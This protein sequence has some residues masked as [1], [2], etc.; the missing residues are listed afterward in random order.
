MV[1][2]ID[3]VDY[4][5]KLKENWSYPIATSPVIYQGYQANEAYRGDKWLLTCLRVISAMIA[6]R[7]TSPAHQCY[8]TRD[9]KGKLYLD[10]ILHWTNLAFKEVEGVHKKAHLDVLNC[11]ITDIMIVKTSSV[12]H[13]TIGTAMEEWHS[14]N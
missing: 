13:N 8:A 7:V 6:L 4:D 5:Q 11:R 10:F 9:S 14:S 3:T 12:M 2:K 1:A